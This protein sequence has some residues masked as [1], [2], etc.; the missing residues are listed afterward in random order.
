MALLLPA[1]LERRGRGPAPSHAGLA[2]GPA[3]GA[4]GARG[5]GPGSAI[6]RQA[7]DYL[8]A[9]VLQQL[10]PGL[11]EFLLRTSVLH[12]LDAAAARR[13]PATRVPGPTSTRW[14][15]WTC[16]SPW[17]ATSPRTLKLHDLFR[18]A[19]RTACN[20]SAADE[21]LALLARAAALES[22]LVRR[23]ALLLAAGARTTRPPACA[24]AASGLMFEGGVHTVVRLAE[25]FP[26]EFAR[27][28][29]DL[30]DVA[31]YAKW[32]LWRNA[33]ADQHLQAAEACTVRAAT[34]PQ[35]GWR[36]CAAPP[37]WPA[38]AGPMRRGGRCRQGEP[39]ATTRSRRA[40]TPA[41][42]TPVDRARGRRR[43]QRGAAHERPAGCAGTGAPARAVGRDGALAAPDR[44]P[45]RRP[46]A[47]ALGRCG[48][49]AESESPLL[50]SALAPMTRGWQALWAG[51]LDEAEQYLWRSESDE[52]W[53]G[54]PPIVHSHRLAFT[55]VVH[56]AK[57]RSR[58][59]PGG[60]ARAWRRVSGQLRRPR[61]LVFD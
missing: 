34:R 25:Q 37:C 53:V 8:T 14:S 6:D 17:S 16:S 20:S 55:A 49:L 60:R 19:L 30:Q 51:R 43:A 54:H 32:R 13:S 4:G 3:A 26:P 50:L 57:G 45:R 33:E 18:D 2:G 36:R 22:D 59:G 21:W 56:M 58:A 44:L 61:P 52:R 24:R 38:S 47:A 27:G 48:G 35:R 28:S 7:F 41:S 40:S 15:G 46:A 39:D 42:V 12:E 1:G 29:A 11:R 5:A 9:E 23:Q 10:E 31:G